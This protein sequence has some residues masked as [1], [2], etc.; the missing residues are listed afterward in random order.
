MKL[1]HIK[2]DPRNGGGT[3][4]NLGISTTEKLTPELMTIL[5]VRLDKFLDLNTPVTDS[6]LVSKAGPLE[7]NIPNLAVAIDEAVAGAPAVEPLP[8]ARARRTRSA[9]PEAPKEQAEPETPRR[10]RVRAPAP[11]VEISDM[12]LAKAASEAADRIGVQ[13]VKDII[14]EF[15]VPTVNQIKGEDKRKHFLELL[16]VD[17][18]IV[19]EDNN[20]R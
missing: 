14:A 17:Y 6:M 18:K 5:A 16:A 12:D 1:E 10:T 2:V 11:A 8:T 15:G 3:W 20:E 4:I 9:E 19:E 13:A 7:I